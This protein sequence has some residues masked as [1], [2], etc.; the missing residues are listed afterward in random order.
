MYIDNEILYKQTQSAALTKE[1]WGNF[2]IGTESMWSNY[3]H[4]M[5]AIRELEN[6]FKPLP[7]S[8]EANNM[9]A[10]LKIVL[11]YKTF[12]MTDIFGDMPFFDA[13]Y[14]F[15]DL[16]YLRP[17]FDSQESIYTY[18]LDELQWCDENIDVT[19]V[20]EEPFPTFSGFDAL[21]RG[22]ML[23]WQKFANSLRMRYALRMSEKEPALAGEII[24][25]IVEN[26]RPIFLGY[27]FTEYLGESACLWP[28]ANGVQKQQ[29][30]LVVPGT[31]KPAHGFKYLASAILQRQYRWQRDFRSP[32]LY[33]F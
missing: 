17:K 12:K 11:A 18:L 14:G 22:D 33:L 20:S 7:D 15:Q 27:N 13:G 21:F 16:K 10:M 5:P 30:E 23:K 26:A 8:A 3:Y 28:V 25:G 19:A 2:T 31:Q 1:A 4:T 24:K 29:P 9:R 6:R 32:G